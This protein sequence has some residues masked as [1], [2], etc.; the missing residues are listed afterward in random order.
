M[1]FNPMTA[2]QYLPLLEKKLNK[3]RAGVK[4]QK[5]VKEKHQPEL[6]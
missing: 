3:K 4:I 6:E 2:Q 5:S 1:G